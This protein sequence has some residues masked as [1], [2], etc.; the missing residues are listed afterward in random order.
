MQ[1]NLENSSNCNI[2]KQNSTKP[3][4]F[5]ELFSHFEK[6][7][8]FDIFFG[9]FIFLK[10]EA[11]RQF[12][13]VPTRR[14]SEFQAHNDLMSDIL[15]DVDNIL[16]DWEVNGPKDSKNL[17]LRDVLE[18]ARQRKRSSGSLY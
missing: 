11:G 7:K 10:V 15:S 1:F 3:S 13:R 9:V 12:Y 14:S 4:Q 16:G 2:H 17:W 5:D 6:G 8:R 18:N